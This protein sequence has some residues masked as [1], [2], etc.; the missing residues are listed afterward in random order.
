MFRL[1]GASLAV[2]I[3]AVLFSQSAPAFEVASVKVHDGDLQILFNFSSSGARAT[4]RAFPLAGLIEEA[5]GIEP[6]QLSFAP[7]V[8]RPDGQLMYDVFAKAE[9]DQPH[10]RPE[11]RKMLQA[12]LADRFKLAVHRETKE[13]PVYALVV[14]KGGPKFKESAP[15]AEDVG[16]INIDSRTQNQTLV[17]TKCTME[18]LADDLM[19]FLGVEKPV[20]DRT[21][22]TGFYN[23]KLQA[24]P[25]WKMDADPELG[26]LSASAA[27]QEQ[28]G[29]KLESAK[30]PVEI[31]VV[32]H[33]E[34]PTAN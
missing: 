32:D 1:I 3:P 13:M 29:L 10:A 33:W 25:K 18:S 27:V 24:T 19:S 7:A 31:L 16:R 6:Y 23:I 9:G 5:Y 20:V 4:W 8:Q 21:G 14:G 15:D 2:F 17:A 12:L 34:K 22:L 26:D 30:A 28:L 11:F